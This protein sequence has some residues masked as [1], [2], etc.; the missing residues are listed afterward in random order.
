MLTNG[1]VGDVARMIAD[2]GG[3]VLVERFDE[4]AYDEALR[5][6]EGFNRSPGPWREPAR[7]WFD[8]EKGVERYHAIYV[9]PGKATHIRDP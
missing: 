4:Q 2:T 3:G 5:T 9:N 6:L 8:L 1:D 7:D